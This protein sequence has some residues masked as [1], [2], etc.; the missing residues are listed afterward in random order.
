MAL[1]MTLTIIAVLGIDIAKEKFDVVFLWINRPDK[2]LFK[3]APS[4]TNATP[5]VCP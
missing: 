3:Y 4:N 5:R 1:P 2:P